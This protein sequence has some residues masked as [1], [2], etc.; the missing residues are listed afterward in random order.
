M[1]LENMQR[2]YAQNVRSWG[3]VMNSESRINI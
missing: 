2:I 3:F 1:I